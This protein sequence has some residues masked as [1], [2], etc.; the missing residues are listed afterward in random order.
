MIVGDRPLVEE[1]ATM[2]AERGFSV[3]S[4]ANVELALELTNLSFESKRNNLLRLDDLLPSSVPIISSAVTVMMSE[5]TAWVTHAVRLVGIGAFPTLLHGS[6]LEFVATAQTSAP[7]R[8]AVE[9]FASTL[10]KSAVFVEDTVGLVMPRM[11]CMLI[12]EAYFAMTEGVADDAAIDTAMKLGTNYPR[13]PIEWAQAIGLPHVV[14]VLHALQNY[15]GEDRYRCAPL[16]TKDA[17]RIR[18]HG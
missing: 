7:V 10:G 1:Y 17:Q 18:P 15:Y 8:T 13:G 6:L 3:A 4:D 5:Q 9:A 2:C 16:L 14:A 12:N 11:L